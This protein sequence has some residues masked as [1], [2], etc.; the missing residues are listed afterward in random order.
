MAT[1]SQETLDRL[2]EYYVNN[3]ATL[4]FMSKNS[5]ELFG[6]EIGLEMMKLY[7]SKYNWTLKRRLNTNQTPIAKKIETVADIVYDVIID[8]DTRET[9]GAMSQLVRAWLDLIS[10]TDA[11]KIAVSGKTSREEVLQM[12]KDYEEAKKSETEDV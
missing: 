5:K 12:V 8:P 11:V 7:S 3:Q 2:E 10:R 9:P 1:P 6:Q 4:D